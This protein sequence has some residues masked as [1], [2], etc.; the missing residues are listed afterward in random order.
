MGAF[1]NSILYKSINLIFMLSK[2]FLL[3][4]HVNNFLLIHIY[5]KLSRIYIRTNCWCLEAWVQRACLSLQAIGHKHKRCKWQ[6]LPLPSTVSI[7]IRTV[8]SIPS[9]MYSFPFWLVWGRNQVYCACYSYL[10][11][12]SWFRKAVNMRIEP[13]V[14]CE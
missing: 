7:Y 1:H 2:R 8:N 3:S 13:T 9:L 4:S 12:I 10:E 6:I 5:R 14:H 11:P